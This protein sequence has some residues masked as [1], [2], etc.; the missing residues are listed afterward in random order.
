MIEKSRYASIL[1]QIG[2]RPFNH[3]LPIRF[4]VFANILF[5]L[6]CAG[7]LPAATERFNVLFIATDDLNNHL[8]CFGNP[9][10]KTPNL[11]RLAVRGTRFM[12]AYC[13]FPLC[14]PS[15]SSLLTGLRPDSIKIYDLK[16]H[17]RTTVPDVVTLP[18][19]FRKNGYFTARVGKIYHYGV[20]G[21]IGTSGLDDPQSWD[22]FVN[23]KGRDKAEEHLLTNYTPKRG[24]GS[25]LSFLK[26]AGT[27]EEQTDGIGVNETIK[28]L[29]ANKD[30]P[31]FIAMGFYRPHCPYISPAKYFER[32]SME[33]IAIPTL[34]NAI[35]ENIPK[36]SLASTTPW[37]WFGVTENQARESKQAYYAAISFVDNRIGLLLDTLKELQL[38][39]NTIIV[40]W[41]DNGYHLGEHG[42]WKKQS[43]FEESA[44][45]PLLI[46][47]PRQKTKGQM[48]HRIVELLDIYPT[49]ADLCGLKAPKNLAGTSLRPLL[50]DPQISWSRPAITQ[51]QRGGAKNPVM[52]Y[53]V[54]TER[55]RYTEW[56]QGSQGMELYD[57]QQ[58]PQEQ[59]NL[60]L[61]PDFANVI[62][63]M[64]DILQQKIATAK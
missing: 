35:K 17:F 5:L 64:K 57:H 19:L 1:R 8:G 31:F 53:S 21:D 45:V 37:P 58:D 63:S 49:L 23:P 40:F 13:Q 56:D 39:E 32:F 28:L 61:K 55:W 25:S 26:A 7:K 50:D 41:S 33:E 24:L 6:F 18:E 29:R 38:E 34:N 16:K 10:V 54:R 12:N 20:P 14:S 2:S 48:S 51:T 59:Q 15:R 36:F 43:L 3:I 47:A 22:T 60:A 9:L 11:D 52:G 44:R 42:L 27:E 30:K 4:L 46:A 62:K